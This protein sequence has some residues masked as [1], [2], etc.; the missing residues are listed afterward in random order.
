MGSKNNVAAS[1]RRRLTSFL[2]Q[3]GEQLG[4]KGFWRERKMKK[5]R[6][7][8]VI[9]ALSF[10]DF[11]VLFLKPVTPERLKSCDRRHAGPVSASCTLLSNKVSSNMA[12]TLQ[13]RITKQGSCS[14]RSCSGKSRRGNGAEFILL[15][16]ASKERTY[17]P[18]ELFPHRT[19]SR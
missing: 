2:T 7:T 8:A 4:P 10:C 11:M 15:S 14:G 13:S 3:I 5:K 12:W 9:V 19:P 18:L 6:I 17:G 1:L 16:R